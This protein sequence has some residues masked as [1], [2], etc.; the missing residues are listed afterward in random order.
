MASR[1]LAVHRKTLLAKRRRPRRAS[2][3]GA[4]VASLIFP[5]KPALPEPTG[6]SRQASL[7]L[8]NLGVFPRL[9][10]FQARNDVF[11]KS[12]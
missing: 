11:P 12:E 10:S 1:A 7:Y 9:L 6:A 4:L 8:N 2:S 5:S 3:A